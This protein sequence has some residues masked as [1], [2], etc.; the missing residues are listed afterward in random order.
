MLPACFRKGLSEKKYQKRII[1]NE[2]SEKGYFME[3][4]YMAA[5]KADFNQIAEQFGISPVLARIIRNR[6]VEGTEQI[7]KFLYGGRE[8]LYSPF[9]LKGMEEAVELLKKAVLEK[10]RI[11]VIGDYDV[12]GICSTYILTEGLKML[13]ATVDYAIPHRSLDGYGLN[14][15]LIREAKE[16]GTEWI[17]TCD[18]GIAAEKQV[19]LANELGMKVLVTDHHEVPYEQGET[20]IRFCLPPA[21]AVIDPKQPGCTYPFRDICG[22]LVAYK[23]I[24]ALMQRMDPENGKKAE[25]RFLPFA[26]LGT[27]CDV[28]PLRDENRIVVKEG[29]KELRLRPSTGLLALMQVNG[30]APAA[31]NTYQLGFVLGPCMNSS[32]RLDTALRAM[33]LLTCTDIEKAIPIAA[34]LKEL[35]DSRKA[36]TVK[37]VEQARQLIE[38]EKLQQDK[39]LVVY[40]PDC[41][42]SLAG[43]IAGRLRELYNKPV[44]VL[45]DGQDEAKGSGRSID[46]Y[47]MYEEMT[48][49][50]DCFL[51]F[52]GHRLAAGFSLEKDKITL[53][54]ERLNRVC[55]LTEEDL[56]KRV[57]ID[58]PMPLSYADLDLAHE[59]ELLEPFGTGNPKPL[60][61]Q[62]ELIFLK[63]R[64][65]GANKNF[66]RYEVLDDKRQKKELVYFG[67][68]ER[69]HAFLDQRFGAG[70]AEALYAGNMQLPVTITYQL[71]VHTYQGREKLQLLLQD[72]C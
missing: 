48:K 10:K 35:N 12:D 9:L 51:K 68:L 66:A 28:M 71:G 5:K 59:L 61:A 33:E 37:G 38:Q 53:L 42:E 46:A 39:V 67:N 62:K 11:R 26:A 34:Q 14:E 3:K 58:V 49:C 72:Y 8:E 27:V 43:I 52:G 45:T 50:R 70:T 56:V 63:G 15:R 13:G 22:A 40:L 30:L 6:D 19:Q 65:I 31:V 16:A 64:R 60:F 20:G 44:F 7:Q 32:G 69:F 47:D 4:W 18:N 36:M 54:R 25:D 23:V 2:V 24:Q 21:E 17:L 1:E 55:T 41:H 57:H 29:L